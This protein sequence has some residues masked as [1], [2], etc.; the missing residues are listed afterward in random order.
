MPLTQFQVEARSLLVLFHSFFHSLIY[1]AI[2]H[3][4]AFGQYKQIYWQQNMFKMFP[5]VVVI[6]R[7][8]KVTKWCDLMKYFNSVYKLYTLTSILERDVTVTKLQISLRHCRL[9]KEINDQTKTHIVFHSPY[10]P[11]PVQVCQSHLVSAVHNNCLTVPKSHM[12]LLFYYLINWRKKEHS[13]CKYGTQSKLLTG[14]H[15]NG[16]TLCRQSTLGKQ[17]KLLTG[18]RFAFVDLFRISEN[19]KKKFTELHVY[20]RNQVIF[21]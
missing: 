7:I 17:L 1:S 6:S 8:S 9:G 14:Q 3:A 13:F 20:I 21:T 19:S 16:N 10:F 18:Q 15:F 11:L 5:F 12:Q 2:W 4:N